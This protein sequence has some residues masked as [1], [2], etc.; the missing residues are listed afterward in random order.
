MTAI[1][2]TPTSEPSQ[3]ADR[4]SAILAAALV[5][6]SEKGIEAATIDD[7]RQR[8]QA[9]VGSIYHHFGNKE[10]IAAALFAQ[11]LD[12]Y[13]GQILS[14]TRGAP[15][16]KQAI[17]ALLETH[18][19]WIVAKPDLARFLFA[20]RQAVGPAHEQAIRQRTAD[21]FK[22]YFELFKPWFKQGIL[23]R[24]PF[25]LY[26]PLLLGAAQELSRHW[27]GGRVT[28]DPR[29]AVDELSRAAWLSLATDPSRS[30]SP[31]VPS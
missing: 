15:D 23:R 4:K 9:S 27:L 28:L 30:G 7:I 10:S 31:S 13:W 17:H 2:D 19:G 24:L 6:F 8:S 18:L 12:D 25:E 1:P 14:R 20:R 16:A 3:P 29:E 5:V 26:G 22:E 21:H 11:G